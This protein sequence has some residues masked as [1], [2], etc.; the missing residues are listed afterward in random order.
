MAFD[1]TNPT[2]LATL[3]TEVKTDPIRMGYVIQGNVD[4]ILKKLNSP[5]SNIGGETIPRPFDALA[6]MEALDPTEFD[7]QQTEGGA[8]TYSHMLLELA[9][10]SSIELFKAKFKS[11]F[12]AN[13]ATVTALN[14]QEIDLSRAEVLFGVGTVISLLDWQTARDS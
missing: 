12:A 11:M 3:K 14:A 10:Y 6:L 8:M 9:A 13:S 2:H 1:R 4:N 7:A 5:D